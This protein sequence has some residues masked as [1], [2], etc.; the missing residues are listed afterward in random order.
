ME[1]E[2][3]GDDDGAS[4]NADPGILECRQ[5]AF[6]V[7][8]IGIHDD[9]ER[10]EDEDSDLHLLAPPGSK[11]FQLAVLRENQAAPQKEE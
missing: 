11:T 4:H 7:G 10:K 6:A 9:Q 3:Y 5:A 8:E 1:H 2:Q